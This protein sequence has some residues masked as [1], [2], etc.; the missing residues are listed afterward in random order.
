MADLL[1]RAGT[2]DP[3]TNRTKWFWKPFRIVRLLLRV[4]YQDPSLPFFLGFIASKGKYA[5]LGGNTPVAIDRRPVPTFTRYDY[6][7]GDGP[8]F[9]NN[10]RT[11]QA[12]TPTPNRCA[13][14]PPQI[15][16]ESPNALAITIF[17]TRW[18]M[19]NSTYTT[20]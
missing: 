19:A 18:A 10:A 20:T 4:V 3:S 12:N 5:A 2:Q 9:V 14:T 8:I 16:P 7:P 1:P 6:R 11:C 15:T 17:R 13:T